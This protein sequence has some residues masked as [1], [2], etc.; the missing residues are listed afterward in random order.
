MKSVWL[1]FLFSAMLWGD[2]YLIDDDI[3]V[4]LAP[5]QS[6]KFDEQTVATLPHIKREH[7]TLTLLFE[8]E[9][10]NHRH[11]NVRTATLEE[12]PVYSVLTEYS[13]QLAPTRHRITFADYTFYEK[14]MLQV[15]YCGE[16]YAAILEALE[17]Q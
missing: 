8:G 2:I 9:A 13:E 6:P 11:L 16:W 7:A 14:L 12:H 5:L 1:I 15:Y 10:Y 3:K 4:K 17:E